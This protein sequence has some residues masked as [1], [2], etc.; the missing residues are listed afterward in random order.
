MDIGGW[1][2]PGAIALRLGADSKR[3][4]LA[5]LAEVA[6]RVIDMPAADILDALLERLGEP[7]RQRS[8]AV[9]RGTGIAS[10]ASY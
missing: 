7:K 9:S 4:A 10:N 6:A 2:E 3:Q 8:S 1:L 5:A